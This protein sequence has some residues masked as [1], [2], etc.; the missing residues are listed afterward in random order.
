MADEGEGYL[1]RYNLGDL[2]D[3][4]CTRLGRQFEARITGVD[5][6]WKAG[7]QEVRVMLGEGLCT[8]MRRVWRLAR[9]DVRA[10]MGAVVS[11]A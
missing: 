6:V 2:C 4:V 8:E 5:E 3:V 7:R 1:A 9:S 11:K 10:R